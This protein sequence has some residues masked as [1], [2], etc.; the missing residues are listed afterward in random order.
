MT[1][2][3]SN[4]EIHSKVLGYLRNPND[5]NSVIIRGL[6]TDGRSKDIVSIGKNII[7]DRIGRYNSTLDRYA[8]YLERRHMGMSAIVARRILR[9]FKNVDRAI[10]R[11]ISNAIPYI[12]NHK[13]ILS[14]EHEY[15]NVPPIVLHAMSP[16]TTD[17]FTE[18]GIRC[19]RATDYI[20]NDIEY[21]QVM[22]AELYSCID[23]YQLLTE[24]VLDN[25]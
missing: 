21:L 24:L 20:N 7:D 4:P 11:E 22:K 1:S 14:T 15:F 12:H 16:W 3:Q 10:E 17:F 18:E 6:I 5:L 8:G 19:I 25:Q 2:H 23:N 9:Q 13:F